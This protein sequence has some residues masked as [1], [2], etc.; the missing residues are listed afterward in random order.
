MD[1]ATVWSRQQSGRGISTQNLL[2]QVYF[3]TRAELLDLSE[4][5]PDT[6]KQIRRAAAVLALTRC[7][8]KMARERL[9]ESG[10][11]ME[12]MSD[13]TINLLKGHTIKTS[14]QLAVSPPLQAQGPLPA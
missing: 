3:I 6:N 10:V 7:L 13:M 8:P 11:K 2:S 12:H 4:N 9:R 5:Y 1:W 14:S